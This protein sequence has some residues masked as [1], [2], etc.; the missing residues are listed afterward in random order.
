LWGKCIPVK[1]GKNVSA[2]RIPQSKKEVAV[3]GGK[4][5]GGEP[6]DRKA[7]GRS[8]RERGGEKLPPSVLRENELV[9]YRLR[10]KLQG[11]RC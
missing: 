4:V 6:K 10:R 11:R 5:R 7:R 8:Y 1:G 3:K 2:G 9:T